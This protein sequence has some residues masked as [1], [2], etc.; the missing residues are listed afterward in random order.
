MWEAGKPLVDW[1]DGHPMV[2]AIVALFLPGIPQI[3]MGHFLVG[4]IFLIG[5]CVA[6]PFLMGWLVAIIAAIHAHMVTPKE[7]KEE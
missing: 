4:I 3:L 6:W 5:A 7:P 1:F 2:A